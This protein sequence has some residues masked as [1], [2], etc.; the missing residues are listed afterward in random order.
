MMV[1][2]I[3][4][5][6]Q[7]QELF[8]TRLSGDVL[9]DE[10]MV[11]AD[12]RTDRNV[13]G[14]QR[15]RSDTRV[16][17]FSRFL[18]SEDEYKDV[19]PTCP[20]SIVLNVRGKKPLTFRDSNGHGVGMLDLT[21]VVLWEVDGQHRV[22]GFQDA[23]HEKPELGAFDFPAVI[24]N[25]DKVNEAATFFLIN[26]KQQR[27]ST[28]LCQ[29]ILTENLEKTTLG[30]A[31][32]AQ[33]K[34]WTKK[35]LEVIDALNKTQGQPWYRKIITPG[36][37]GGS[38]GRMIRQNSFLQS[39]RPLLTSEPYKSMTVDDLLKL[40]TRYWNAVVARLPECFVEGK[41]RQ[42]VLQKSAGVLALHSIAP[43]IFEQARRMGPIITQA[44]IETV[45]AH[46]FTDSGPEYWDRHNAQGAA[47]FG[48]SNKGVRFL[49]SQLVAKLPAPEASPL[50]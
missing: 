11:K 39:L 33:G 37:E 28:D 21:D 26:T 48:S 15:E 31:L 24:M 36:G 8:I 16:R 22:G 50:V 20:N 44:N 3:R 10:K 18:R 17:E 9:G 43:T 47:A 1:P 25:L 4:L 14:Y 42:Y 32:V 7:G 23:I 46:I 2:A 35:A 19:K 6:Q 45:L 49:T 34:D 30:Q 13:E 27:V 41:Q 5:A 40:L 38:R 12:I 29:R